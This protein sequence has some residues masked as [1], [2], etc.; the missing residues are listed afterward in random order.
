MTVP[1]LRAGAGALQRE[2]AL[3]GDEA[4]W[5]ISGVALEGAQE[6]PIAEFFFTYFLTSEAEELVQHLALLVCPR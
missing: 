6:G 5:E 3:M 2:L 1:P 4:G